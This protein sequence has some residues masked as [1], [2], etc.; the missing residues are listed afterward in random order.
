MK[1]ILASELVNHVNQSVTVRGWLNNLRA[2]GKLNFLILRDRTGF[3]QVV[4]DNKE[5]YRKVADLQPGS[6]LTISG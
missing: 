1:R 5:D 3:I 6:I 2:F 4:I